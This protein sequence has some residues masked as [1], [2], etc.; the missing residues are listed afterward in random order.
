MKALGIASIED[1]MKETSFKM[2][3]TCANILANW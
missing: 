3:W 2:V 1:K